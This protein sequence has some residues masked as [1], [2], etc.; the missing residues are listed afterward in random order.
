MVRDVVAGTG[1]T[2]REIS[3]WLSFGLLPVIAYLCDRP[4]WRTW[5]VAWGLIAAGWWFAGRPG[6]EIW[7]SDAR[8]AMWISLALATH[9]AAFG[10]RWVIY[11][12][13]ARR[14][15]GLLRLLLVGWTAAI[16]LHPSVVLY[17]VS[18]DWYDCPCQKQ[19]LK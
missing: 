13:G 8:G 18:R 15:P 7:T 17:R 12:S 19:Q 10:L 14:R 11:H 3:G 5:T 4:R 6:R 9:A 2:V 16:L 1:T